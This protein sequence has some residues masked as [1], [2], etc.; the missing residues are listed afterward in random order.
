MSQNQAKFN[1]LQSLGFASV[2]GNYAAV[3][4][5]IT[6]PIS[7]FRITNNTDGDMIFSTDGLTD[8]MFVAA[9]TFVLYDIATNH[10]LAQ[11]FG[12]SGNIQFSVKQSTAPSKG[13]VYVESIS[14]NVT[15]P[16]L[17]A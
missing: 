12:L 10:G 11:A 17:F 2:S 13:S 16:S 9:F 3:G 4:S 1:A 15:T 7:I 6:L 5:P 8:Q 14:P